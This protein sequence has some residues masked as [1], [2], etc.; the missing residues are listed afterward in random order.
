[1]APPP[2]RAPVPPPPAPP[3]LPPGSPAPAPSR[4][5]LRL[6]QLHWA[7]LGEAQVRG[8]RTVWGAGADPDPIPVPLDRRHLEELFA[9]PPAAPRGL[10]PLG[11]P[12][13]QVSLLDAKKILNLGIFLKQLKRPLRQIV[14]DLRDGAGALYGAEK[15]LELRKMLPDAEEARKLAAFCGSRGQLSEPELFML[16]LTEVP[17]YAQRLELLVL[18]EEFFPRLNALGSSIQVQTAATTELL[19]CKE[20]HIILHLILRAGNH[21]NT[22]GY[23]GQA[24]GFRMASLLR[25]M[26]TKAN[27]PG[28]DLLHFVAMEAERMER[29]LLDF[30]SKLQHVGP[31]SRIVEQ[32]VAQ[33]LQGLAAR[34]EGAQAGLEA[35]GLRAQLGPFVRVAEVALG[36]VQAALAH[37]RL[38]TAALL[39]FYCE[40]PECSSLQELCAVM[41]TFAVRFLAAVQENEARAQA[42]QRRARLERE[43]Q[44]KRR[45]IATCS[46]R[47]ANLP[48]PDLDL[49]LWR[50]PRPRRPARSPRGPGVRL[51][52]PPDLQ[53]SPGCP[54]TLLGPRASAGD[55]AMLPRLSRRHTVP[56]LPTLPEPQDP[57]EPVPTSPPPPAPE[58]MGGI[59]GQGLKAWLPEQP[60]AP[61]PAAPLAR[62]RSPSS[63]F[64]FSSLFHKKGGQ[65]QPVSPGAQ[66]QPRDLSTLVGFFRCLSTVGERW[67]WAP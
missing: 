23:A 39:D 25:L 1:M 19:E 32:D 54:A 10:S 30:P 56:T 27:R 33:E 62:A 44:Q 64:R 61:A 52:L 26:D 46:A 11:R 36:E 53:A 21:L 3:P 6:R 38:A 12:P 60:P 2:P 13:G 65:D 47:D 15:L 8:R 34:L 14:A 37:L 20:L 43:R 29:G 49:L 16:L 58:H 66:P 24:A 67:R 42:E 50:P 51:C 7:A 22:G 40:D 9:E 4:A 17:G 5:R 18:R 41:H 28:M 57:V 35:L 55:C 31:A 59:F 48:Q 63:S 45:S